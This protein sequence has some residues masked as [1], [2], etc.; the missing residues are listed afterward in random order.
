MAKRRKKTNAVVKKSWDVG[1]PVSITSTPGPAAPQTSMGGPQ[2]GVVQTSPPQNV[3]MYWPSPQNYF[4]Q[5]KDAT[6]RAIVEYATLAAQLNNEQDT[7]RRV[8]LTAKANQAIQNAIQGIAIGTEAAELQNQRLRTGDQ[9]ATYELK[10]TEDCLKRLLKLIWIHDMVAQRGTYPGVEM[11]LLESQLVGRINRTTSLFANV[12]GIPL[13]LDK[14]E[15]PNTLWSTE[16]T[17]PPPPQPITPT[18]PQIQGPE[19]RAAME[20]QDATPMQQQQEAN[21]ARE[22]QRVTLPTDLPDSGSQADEPETTPELAPEGAEGLPEGEEEE[23]MD[24]REQEFLEREEKIAAREKAVADREEALAAKESAIGAPEEGQE[25]I[26]EG[27]APEEEVAEGEE[28]EGLEEEVEGEEEGVEG[29]EDEVEG[30][31]EEEE[32]EGEEEEDLTHCIECDQMVTP[33]EIEACDNPR[34]PLKAALAEKKAKEEL[35]EKET[36]P[37]AIKHVVMMDVSDHTDHNVKTVIYKEYSGVQADFCIDCQKL[38]AYEFDPA[39]W[40]NEQIKMWTAKQARLEDLKTKGSEE[41]VVSALEALGHIDDD[42]ITEVVQ[43]KRYAGLFEEEEKRQEESSDHLG[44]TEKDIDAIIA[45]AFQ[46]EPSVS[47]N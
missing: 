46:V 1:I 23:V 17:P 4:A 40:D 29:E 33:E 44:I 37:K 15:D 45:K 47:A 32:G 27:E 11:K 2:V 38:L 3:G 39:S 34:C 26:T 9:S 36:D 25:E 21:M 30:E 10:L 5:C 28:A 35:I 13:E 8:D 20:Q 18:P 24:P 6:R 7:Q 22:D 41:I 43:A 12:D 31:G 19:T 42:F 14:G 16:Y